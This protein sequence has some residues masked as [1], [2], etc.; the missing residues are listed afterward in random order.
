MRINGKN[1][2]AQ[3]LLSFPHSS[4]LDLRIH[5]HGPGTTTQ[6]RRLL[7]NA[8]VVIFLGWTAPSNHAVH[9]PASAPDP[10]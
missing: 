3:S 8:A 6:F 5:V 10:A 7:S 1:R 2:G 9:A 4:S